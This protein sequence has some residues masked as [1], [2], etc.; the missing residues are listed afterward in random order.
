ME[1]EC[2]LASEQDVKVRAEH[3]AEMLELWLDSSPGDDCVVEWTVK[4]PPR[5]GVRGRL[6]AGSIV[7]RGTGNSVDIETGA[8]DLEITAVRGPIQAKTSVGTIRATYTGDAAGGVSARTSVGKADL[9][10]DGRK[11]GRSRAPGAGDSFTLEGEG[12]NTIRLIAEVGNI[13]L[14]LH[15]ALARRTPRP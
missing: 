2:A 4:L 8:G 14:Y 11:L 3:R 6:N 12:R 1:R 15:R 7:T 13:E 5:I 10:L 9:Y